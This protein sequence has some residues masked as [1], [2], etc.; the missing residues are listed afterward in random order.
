MTTAT[1]SPFRRRSVHFVPGGND[2]FWAKALDCAADTLIIDLEDSVPADRKPRARAAACEWIA[3]FD[4]ADGRELM[5]RVNALDTPWADDD[6]RTISA[7]GPHSLMIPKVSTPAELDSV[8]HLSVDGAGGPLPLFPV[9]T[10]TALGVVNV[11]AIAAHPHVDG[12]CWGAED[13]SSDLGAQSARLPGG[14]LRP[15]FETVRHLCLLGAVAAGVPAVDAVYTDIRDLA[16]LRRDCESAAAMG[17]SG[18]ITVHPDQIDVV[19]DAFTPSVEA[20][21]RAVALVDAFATNEAE[22]R[23]SFVFEGEMVDAPHLARARRLLARA[24]RLPATVE[25]RS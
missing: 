18:K 2:R 1:P 22:G 7:A 15:I 3:G 13:L 9:A 10:E 8:A 4:A 5:V 19:N 12:L 21:V 24:G 23:S 20:V 14:T 25:A 16:G 6:I 11:H 17:Y